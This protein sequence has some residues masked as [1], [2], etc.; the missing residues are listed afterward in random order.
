MYRKLV[1]SLL[2]VAIFVSTA[3]AVTL[4][5]K[6]TELKDWLL[7]GGSNGADAWWSFWKAVNGDMA[8]TVT[9]ATPAP[10]SPDLYSP[11]SQTVRVAFTSAAGEECGWY[12]GKI[13]V[14]LSED[15][16]GDVHL[17]NSGDV[18]VTNGYVD[19]TLSGT[20][21]DPVAGKSVWIVASLDKFRPFGIS[22]DY[23][24][25]T[26]RAGFLIKSNSTVT[27]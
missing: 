20:D 9:F 10:D 1:V 12:V 24:I 17:S 26:G 5:S 27:Q 18:D 14:S 7:H 13:S 25:P 3:S 4:G 16:S 2:A 11:W 23:A 21:T 8:V 15:V 22:Q 6:V 19:L